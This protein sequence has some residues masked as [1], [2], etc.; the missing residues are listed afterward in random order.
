MEA[1]YLIWAVLFQIWAN[2]AKEMANSEEASETWK[3]FWVV[4][5][6]VNTAAVFFYVLLAFLKG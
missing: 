3:T 2:N 6:F 1:T 4:L 5:Y